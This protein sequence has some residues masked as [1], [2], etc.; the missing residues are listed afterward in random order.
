MLNTAQEQ[1]R[2][3]RQLSPI[4]QAEHEVK[5]RKRAVRE[6]EA[7][8]ESLGVWGEKLGLRVALLAEA[9]TALAEL[10]SQSSD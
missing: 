8:I 7:A 3:L 6:A 4:K 1:E 10:K 2:R 5:K 9:E